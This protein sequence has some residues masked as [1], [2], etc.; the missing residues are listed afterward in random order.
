MLLAIYLRQI[1]FIKFA[2]RTITAVIPSN[3]VWFTYSS[4]CLSK[5]FKNTTESTMRYRKQTTSGW[6]QLPQDKIEWS[7][8]LV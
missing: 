8:K 4:T 7:F 2:V 6:N 3:F 1:F 5:H